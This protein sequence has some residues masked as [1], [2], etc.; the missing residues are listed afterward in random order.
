M[1]RKKV[2]MQDIA[3]A[4]NLSRNTVSKVFNDR[5]SVPEATRQLVL[6]KAAELGYNSLAPELLAEKPAAPEPFLSGNIALLSSANPLNHNFGSLFTKFFTDSV[7]RS[8]FTVQMYE[9]SADEI[10]SHRLP[11][12]LSIEN[13][14]GIIGIELFDESFIRYVA[15]FGLP[16]VFMDCYHAVNRSPIPCDI[17]SM[18]NIAPVMQITRQMLKNGAES[19]GFIGD[20]MHCNSFYERYS[21]VGYALAEA[22][23]AID[24]ALSITAPDSPAYADIGWIIEQLKS[25]PKLPD[26]FVCANDYHAIK[27]MMALR[28]MGISVPEDVK[29]SGFDDSPEASVIGSGLTTVFINGT[30]LGL[31]A[32]DLLVSRLKTPARPYSLTY[33]QSKA[34]FRNS[35]N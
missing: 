16:M 29:V 13:T 33:L 34:V 5:G 3:T 22:G 1:P 15:S 14:V 8:G 19:F 12:R 27:L 4:C 31:L 10:R 11:E 17:I 30:E 20:Y 28:E 21:A 2:T 9:L 7:C 32:A 23:K 35:T 24:P 26:A 18:E 6:A 25:M